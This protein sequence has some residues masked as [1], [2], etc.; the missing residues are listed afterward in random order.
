MIHY[1]DADRDAVRDTSE[2]GL[3][4]SFTVRHGGTFFAAISLD[5]SGST[6]MA[7]AP[8]SYSVEETQ[9]AGWSSTDP[10]GSTLLKSVTV[11]SGQ[12][13]VVTF[14][15]ARVIIPSTSR[16]V[17][18]QV[19]KYEDRDHNGRRDAGE[20]GLAG[21]TFVVRDAVGA[22]VATMTTDAQGIAT[23]PELAPGPYTITEQ[24]QAGWFNTDPGGTAAAKQVV[25]VSDPVTVAF[26]NARV[27]LPSTSTDPTDDEWWS[28]F[29]P[30]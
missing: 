4:G 27:Q 25:L 13:T 28:P 2:P 12:T 7:L 5:A 3:A 26:G 20:A 24:P 6:S 17:T 21:W 30:F 1:Q 8:G 18:I 9:Q 14:G 15:C 23:S 29:I 10:G 19:Q 22:S 11:V 16:G